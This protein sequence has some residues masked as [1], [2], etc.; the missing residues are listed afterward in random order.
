MLA[1]EASQRAASV[2][3]RDAA[4]HVHVEPLHPASRRDD[5]L[6]PAIDRLVSR[7]ALGPRDLG[8]VAVSIGPGGFTGL[9]IAVATAKMLSETLGATPVAVPSALVAAE[10]CD[11]KGPIIVCLA[12]KRETFWS[13]RLERKADGTWSLDAPGRLERASTFNPAGAAAVLA[14]EFLPD[15][16]RAACERAGVPVMTPEFS[17]AACLVVGARLLAAGRATD[18][19]SLLPLYPREP[20][21][22]TLWE[23]RAARGAK[24]G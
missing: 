8:A 16:A 4:G 21:A 24:S 12:S 9:R 1:I 19:L 2:A 7:C 20:E 13:T 15:E 17:A 23:G 11:V 3:L 6:L 14:D 22:I 18:A 10:A 5:D